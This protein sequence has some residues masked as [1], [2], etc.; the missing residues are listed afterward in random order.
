MGTWKHSEKLWEEGHKE[1]LHSSL[2]G[3]VIRALI[4]A[5]LRHGIGR[6]PPK[7]RAPLR[8]PQFC[9]SVAK[10]AMPWMLSTKSWGRRYWCLDE[11]GPWDGN[12]VSFQVLVMMGQ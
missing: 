12:W 7:L 5:A 6:L 10:H 11:H 2:C 1:L 4:R 8:P 9:T 3:Y